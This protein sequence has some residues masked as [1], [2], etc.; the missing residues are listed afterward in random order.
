[1]RLLA[2]QH[3]ANENIH[4]IRNL[5]DL[6]VDEYGNYYEIVSTTTTGSRLVEVTLSNIYF[7]K[8]F[9][10]LF[11]NEDVKSYGHQHIGAYL[12]DLVNNSI[13]YVQDRNRK[14]FSIQDLIDHEIKVSFLDQTVRH[15]RSKS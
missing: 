12:Q 9:Q 11:V 5:L 6:I 1:M 4:E 14:I 3:L 13:K 15:P 10:R 8:S 2:N 7:E